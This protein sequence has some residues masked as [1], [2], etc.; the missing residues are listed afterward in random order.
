MSGLLTRHKRQTS[1]ACV[2][3]VGGS[4]LSSPRLFFVPFFFA[5]TSSVSIF[6]SKKSCFLANISSV[7]RSFWMASWGVGPFPPFPPPP[8]NNL[9]NSDMSVFNG[10]PTTRA[11]VCVT[12][13]TRTRE[14]ALLPRYVSLPR[15]RSL[16]RPSSRAA[17]LLPLRCCCFFVCV[18]TSGLFQKRAS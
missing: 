14:T 7:S 5:V 15:A 6:F 17:G 9:P 11:L 16:S 13:W 3:D 18:S 8:P 2:C 12:L 1:R 10:K 4:R